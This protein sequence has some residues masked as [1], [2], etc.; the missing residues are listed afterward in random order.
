MFVQSGKNSKNV[1]KNI[2]IFSIKH[3]KNQKTMEYEL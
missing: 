2:G 1:S 3:R